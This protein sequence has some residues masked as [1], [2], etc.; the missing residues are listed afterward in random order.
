MKILTYSTMFCPRICFSFV[1]GQVKLI[2]SNRFFE[3]NRKSPVYDTCPTQALKLSSTNGVGGEREQAKAGIRQGHPLWVGG[4]FETRKTAAIWNTIRGSIPNTKSNSIS[5]THA[6]CYRRIGFNFDFDSILRN[7]KAFL[8]CANTSIN[9]ETYGGCKPRHCWIELITYNAYWH[10]YRN[11][12]RNHAIHIRNQKQKQ[13]MD[14]MMETMETIETNGNHGK[15]GRMENMEIVRKQ[16]KPQGPTNKN[17]SKMSLFMRFQRCRFPRSKIKWFLPLCAYFRVLLPGRETTWREMV[18]ATW[19]EMRWYEI[20]LDEMECEKRRE[21]WDE[22]RR[23]PEMI[24]EIV[25]V[26][27]RR[28]ARIL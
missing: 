21:Q 17:R 15:G 16:W 7:A 25:A 6:K 3:S 28:V 11:A 22:M 2:W 5:N 26:M 1:S 19:P 10:A 13:S 20:S 9:S 8:L 27:L 14:T 18:E 4:P 23:G 24:T 12:Y